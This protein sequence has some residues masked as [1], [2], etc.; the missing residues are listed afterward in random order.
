M[1]AFRLL[2]LRRSAWGYLMAS[3]SLM[4]FLTMGIAVSLMSLNMARVGVPISAVE[5]VVFP[6]IAA[7]TCDGGI[8]DQKYQGM[9][10]CEYK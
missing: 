8:A 3:V 10:C 6:T 1:R 9:T 7:A 5:I 2:L 4:K